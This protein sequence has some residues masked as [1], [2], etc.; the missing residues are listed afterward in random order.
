MR[1]LLCGGGTEGHIAPSLALAEVMK[2]QGD[3]FLFVGRKHG[4]ENKK[5][6]KYQYPYLPIYPTS[7]SQRGDGGPQR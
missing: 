6:L 1:L 3:S 2:Q 7:R 5:I 4:E